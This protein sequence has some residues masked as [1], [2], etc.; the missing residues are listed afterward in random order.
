VGSLRSSAQA[1][2]LGHLDDESLADYLTDVLESTLELALRFALSVP[3]VST[4]LVGLSS[5]EQLE[6]TIRWSERGPLRER[7]VGH[8]VRLAAAGAG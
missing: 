6:D 3:G 4:A 1:H 5:V 7:D 8:L 2:D